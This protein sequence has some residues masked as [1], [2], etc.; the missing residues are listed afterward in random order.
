MSCNLRV[1]FESQRWL[2]F[3]PHGLT[4]NVFSFGIAYHS[5]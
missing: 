3:P 1:D 2:S 4:P 5:Y